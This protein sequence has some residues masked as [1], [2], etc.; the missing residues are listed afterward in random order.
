MLTNFIQGYS[1][2]KFSVGMCRKAGEFCD[3][4]MGSGPAFFTQYVDEIGYT[5]DILIDFAV[6]RTT[7]GCGAVLLGLVLIGCASQWFIHRSKY[8]KEKSWSFI[9]HFLIYVLLC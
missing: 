4:T 1:M 8:V 2:S 7:P 9:V 6:F 3:A 5:Y